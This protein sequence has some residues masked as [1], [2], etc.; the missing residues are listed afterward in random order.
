MEKPRSVYHVLRHVLGCV[1]SL[2]VQR[3]NRK[4]TRQLSGGE[5]SLQ[6]GPRAAIAVGALALLWLSIRG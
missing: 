4:D 1:Q 6:H 3:K 2:T 5:A